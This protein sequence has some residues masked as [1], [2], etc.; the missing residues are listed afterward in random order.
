MKEREERH[1]RERYKENESIGDRTERISRRF[2]E[3]VGE[4]GNSISKE[5]VESYVKDSKNIEN[6]S[7]LNQFV[8][9]PNLNK[10][11]FSGDI[12]VAFS[13][14]ANNNVSSAELSVDKDGLIDIP[15]PDG[16]KPIERKRRSDEDERDRRSREKKDN[17]NERRKEKKSHKLERSR[18]LS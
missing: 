2:T 1:E 17:R 9:Y 11:D 7:E 13:Q 16:E 18:S 3:E 10:I 15:L 4:K 14:P 8:K 6:N 5:D 12:Y